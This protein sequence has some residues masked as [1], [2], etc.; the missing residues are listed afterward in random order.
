M[1][2]RC[3]SSRAD[4]IFRRITVEL[5]RCTRAPIARKEN[6]PSQRPI[7]H[8]RSNS[9]V[10]LQPSIYTPSASVQRALNARTP[11]MRGDSETLTFN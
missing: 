1:W 7:I 6:P 5:F 9:N 8:P 10:P 4:V 11:R 2:S 3:R